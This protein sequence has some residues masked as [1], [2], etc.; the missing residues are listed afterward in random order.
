MT[1]V[2]F[3]MLKAKNRCWVFKPI[4]LFVFQ[5]HCYY[6]ISN[7]GNWVKFVRLWKDELLLCVTDNNDILLWYVG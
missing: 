1:C 7:L 5:G 6:E 2:M 4:G 3:P